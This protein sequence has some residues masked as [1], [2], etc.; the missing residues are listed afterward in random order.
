[1]KKYY[2]LHMLFATS[3]VLFFPTL[4][5]EPI[6]DKKAALDAHNV[7]RKSL[8]AGLYLKQPKPRPAIPL[9]SWDKSLAESAKQYAQ[10]CTW[11]HSNN[12]NNAGENLF[13]G[14]YSNYDINTAVTSWAA[15]RQ[16]YDYTTNTCQTGKQCG[17]YT[18]IVWSNSERVGCGIAYCD[19]L[20]TPDNEFVMGSA[21]MVVCQYGPAGNYFSQQPYNNKRSSIKVNDY[22]SNSKQVDIPSVKVIYP[23]QTS[24]LFN[25]RLLE[26]GANLFQL[27]EYNQIEATLTDNND[28]LDLNNNNLYLG[29]IDV[30]LEAAH[31]TYS[32]V[33]EYIPNSNPMLFKL[34]ESIRHVQ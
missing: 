21:L 32:A 4:A 5:A 19:S 16:Y 2:L 17:H 10:Q 6:L 31:G 27:I 12:R 30:Q 20:K 25:A 23:D 13:A 34:R 3:L 28:S 33:L 11:A 29:E 14:T 22:D 1:M 8:N 7:I 9:Y 18:Q 15:E 24:Q 26:V